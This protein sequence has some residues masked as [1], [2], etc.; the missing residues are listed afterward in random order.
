MD[1]VCKSMLPGCLLRDSAGPAMRKALVTCEE[2]ACTCI[3]KPPGQV[4][5]DPDGLLECFVQDPHGNM[6]DWYKTNVTNFVQTSGIVT[7]SSNV[8]FTLATCTQVDNCLAAEKLCEYRA[9]TNAYPA[10]LECM[11]YLSCM[12]EHGSAMLS[13]CQTGALSF[14]DKSGQQC[15]NSPCL[16]WDFP[17]VGTF[18]NLSGM[19]APCDSKAKSCRQQPNSAGLLTLLAKCEADA[20]GCA[21]G[22]FAV[23]AD[24]VCERDGRVQWCANQVTIA[25]REKPAGNAVRF[26]EATCDQ[27]QRC[28]AQEMS[29]YND[30]FTQFAKLHTPTAE[31]KAW[32]TCYGRL[33][34][35]VSQSCADSYL[36]RDRTGATCD[37]ATVCKAWTFTAPP[38]VTIINQVTQMVTENKGLVAAVVI[39]VLL[40]AAIIAGALA[41][42][43]YRRRNAKS[44]FQRNLGLGP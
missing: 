18:V 14:S 11:V 27:V 21:G 43:C 25:P 38:P 32:Q 20:C 22:G 7:D 39:L 37:A 34:Q 17:E 24:G 15:R 40:L 35:S 36:F 33:A 31:C 23:G 10:S 42:W 30:A 6:V 44:K 5:A 26:T 3:G 2:A 41:W 8:A 13:A 16:S 1:E 28:L 4:S 19:D 29:C 9:V 12:N